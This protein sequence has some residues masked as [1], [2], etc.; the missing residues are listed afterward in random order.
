MDKPSPSSVAPGILSF[1]HGTVLWLLF[2][3]FSLTLGYPTLNRYDPRIIGADQGSYYK[4]V[5]GEATLDD[6]PFRLRVL[7]PSIA[8]PIYL[9]AKGHVGTWNPVWTGMLIANSLCCATFCL[10][11]AFLG[12][13]ILNDLSLALLGCAFVLLNYAAPNLWLSG[14]VDS[15]VAC[16]LMVVTYCIFRN[17]WWPLPLIGI[18]GGLSHQVFLPFATLFGATWWL[19]MEKSKRTFNQAACIAGMA[20]AA[21][22]SMVVTHWFIAGTVMMPWS[23][24]SKWWGGSSFFSNIKGTLSDHR[25]GYPFVWLVPLGAWRLGRF[26]RPW[27]NATLA[28]TAFA[29]GCAIY[30]ELLGT[31]NRPMFD[32]MA[33]LFSMSSACF[34]ADRN[35]WNLKSWPHRRGL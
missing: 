29:F 25:F 15:A 24:A 33:P 32:V 9:L 19:S 8:R 26:P 10:L 6:I 2:F 28:V 23:M 5:V 11:L 7:V 17:T 4:M 12:Y 35:S 31:A 14:Y 20:I 27:V 1:A 3:A 16:L 30:T 34:V 21:V 22:L 18:L 13:R